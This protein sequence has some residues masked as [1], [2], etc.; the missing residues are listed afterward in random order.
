MIN[1]AATVGEPTPE[2]D[3]QAASEILQMLSNPRSQRARLFDAQGN[4]IA[5]S[6]WVADRVEW[7]VLPPAARARTSAARPS[8]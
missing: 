4:L 3:A 7:K 6:Y 1:R 2:L 5:D 8:T